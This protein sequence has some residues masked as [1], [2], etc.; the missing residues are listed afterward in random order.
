M[1]E[2]TWWNWDV[3]GNKNEGWEFNDRSCSGVKYSLTG[4]ETDEEIVRIVGGNPQEIEVEVSW[5]QN[6]I[7]FVRKSDGKPLGE[8]EREN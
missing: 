1:R 6:V 5:D 8:L 2:Y 4:N 7:V 3:W